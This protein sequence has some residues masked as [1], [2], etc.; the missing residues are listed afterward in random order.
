MFLATLLCSLLAIH[1]LTRP[2]WATYLSMRPLTCAHEHSDSLP[3]PG[4]VCV[5][6]CVCFFF[7]LGGFFLV[8]F[9]VFNVW[10]HGGRTRPAWAVKLSMRPQA[11][12]WGFFWVFSSWYL[13]VG[14]MGGG[15]GKSPGIQLQLTLLNAASGLEK[16]ALHLAGRLMAAHLRKQDLQIMQSS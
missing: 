5:R 3:C 9:L 2:A 8:V 4:C 13:F 16:H 15:G 14:C 11:L 12:C 10:G 1:W 7:L 6:V